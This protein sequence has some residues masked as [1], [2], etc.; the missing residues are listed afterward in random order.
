MSSFRYH[1]HVHGDFTLFR[2]DRKKAIHNN[3]SRNFST[4]AY[5]EFL[6]L[7]VKIQ[8]FSTLAYKLYLRPFCAHI[9]FLVLT[10]HISKYPHCI[11]AKHHFSTSTHALHR[12]VTLT[13]PLDHK[14][15]GVLVVNGFCR[16]FCKNISYIIF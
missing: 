16:V 3:G 8:I 14:G 9:L 4:D 6:P 11:D 2:P 12:R 5:V 7:S 15:V 13:I 10:P 1:R